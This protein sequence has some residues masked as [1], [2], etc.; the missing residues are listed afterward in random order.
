MGNSLRRLLLLVG[1]AFLVSACGTQPLRPTTIALSDDAQASKSVVPS[2]A[3]QFLG[4][5]YVY[6]GTTPNGFDCSGLVQYA[7]REVGIDVPRTTMAQYSIAWPVELAQLQPGDLLFF[8]LN[9]AE[10][11]HVAIYDGDLQ[12]IHAPATGKVVSVSSLNNRFWRERLV[13]AGRFF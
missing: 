5:P 4:V 9:S 12:F 6:G 2:V 8:R 11:S 3:R 7:Y 10:V 1:F 13:G